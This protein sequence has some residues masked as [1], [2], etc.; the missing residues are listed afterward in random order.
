MST[1]NS[2]PLPVTAPTPGPA[3]DSNFGVNIPQRI[4]QS[5]SRFRQI[6]QI[7][8]EGLRV[9]VP[10]IV[11]EFF[12]GPPATVSVRFAI[13]ERVQYNLNGV[14]GPINIQATYVPPGGGMSGSQLTN[15]GVIQDVPVI[16]PSAGGWNLTMPIQAGDECLLVFSDTELDSWWQNGGLNN[17]PITARRHSL[18]DAIAVFGLRSTPRGLKNYSTESMQIR[19][20]DGKVVIDL[21]TNGITITAPN[22]TVNATK[23]ISIQASGALTLQGQTVA[24]TS[25]IGHAT[26]DGVVIKTH[27]HSGVQSGGSQTGPPA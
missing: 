19:S 12:P 21:A 14:D 20:D 3:Q 11:Q 15:T 5:T 9:A 18:S 13:N 25:R 1:F 17:K 22:V 2:Q 26:V 27:R 8:N 10:A 6:A 24:I 4:G 7:I 16:F 23:N